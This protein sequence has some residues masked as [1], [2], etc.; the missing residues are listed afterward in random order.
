MTPNPILPETPCTPQERAIQLLR[1]WHKPLVA[2]LLLLAFQPLRDALV[3]W[4]AAHTPPTD[5]LGTAA[6]ISNQFLNLWG[7][8]SKLVFAVIFYYSSGF[9]SFAGMK[10]SPVLP[11]W[12][13]GRYSSPDVLPNPVLDYKAAFLALTDAERLAH[14]ERVAWKEMIRFSACLY[15]ACMVA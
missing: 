10:V 9:F 6:Q 3:H 4:Q 2:V 12:A 15:A 5:R 14:Y 11:D 13:T 1:R 7:P 8:L